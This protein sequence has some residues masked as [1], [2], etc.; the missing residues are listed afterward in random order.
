MS[1]TCTVQ[2]CYTRTPTVKEIGETLFNLYSGAVPVIKDANGDPV[3]PGN[4]PPSAD[5]LIFSDPS[6]NFCTTNAT[7]GTT[8]VSQRKCDLDSNKR[9]ACST[10]C[11]D[12]GHD[13]EVRVE[14]V[15]E[16]EFIWCCRIDCQIT[17]NVTIT[18]YKCRAPH[19]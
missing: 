6:P 18:D 14:P 11:C 2:T 9:N 5:A 7:V 15:E 3:V 8:G 16:C 12:F 4:T 17:A 1:G 13:T 19:S 10:L